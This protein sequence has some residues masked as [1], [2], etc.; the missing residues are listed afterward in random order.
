MKF[1]MIYVP[2][3]EKRRIERK[4]RRKKGEGKR[5]KLFSRMK[6][7]H[8]SVEFTHTYVLFYLY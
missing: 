8:M 4:M 3:K 7:D 5:K 6:T 1:V 2:K